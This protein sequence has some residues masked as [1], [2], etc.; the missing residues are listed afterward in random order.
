[1]WGGPQRLL[2]TTEINAIF[3]TPFGAECGMYDPAE[4]TSKELDLDWRLVTCRVTMGEQRK[5]HICGAVFC[6]CIF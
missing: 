4:A 3:F 6:V 5:T 2:S 1:V